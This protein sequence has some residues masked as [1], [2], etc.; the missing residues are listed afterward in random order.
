[1]ERCVICLPFKKSCFSSLF[2]TFIQN[3]RQIFKQLFLKTYFGENYFNN[4]SLNI[5][6]MVFNLHF[7]YFGLYN[8]FCIIDLYSLFYIW[9]MQITLR[10]V[11]L[12]LDKI[13][14]ALY[15]YC[16]FL[17]QNGYMKTSKTWLRISFDLEVLF[18]LLN[19]D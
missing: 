4:K 11:H 14:I 1:M 10:Y 17:V 9:N 7:E 12:K 15:K 8:T 19:V 18:S 2:G 3:L 6:N 5:I 13:C 16:I